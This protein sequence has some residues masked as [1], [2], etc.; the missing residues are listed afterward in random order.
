MLELWALGE[1]RARAGLDVV[2]G[3]VSQASTCSGHACRA[4]G[5]VHGDLCWEHQRPERG[6][7]EKK[8][9]FL[10]T[11]ELQ[12]VLQAGQLGLGPNGRGGEK[13]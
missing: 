6:R 10:Q 13:T 3:R 11:T 9:D 8:L 5:R 4:C 1:E 2:P 12:A 7:E